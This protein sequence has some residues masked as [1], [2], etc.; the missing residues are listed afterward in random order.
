MTVGTQCQTCRHFIGDGTCEAFFP[1]K[2]PQEILL[3]DV[4]HNKPIKGDN[5]IRYEAI[6]SGK[7]LLSELASKEND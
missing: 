7:S 6:Q 3:G 1:K 5:G 2:I 4:T